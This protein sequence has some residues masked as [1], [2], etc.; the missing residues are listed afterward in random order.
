MPVHGWMLKQNARYALAGWREQKE[1]QDPLGSNMRAASI[2]LASRRD[3]SAAI[4][5]GMRLFGDE[6][7]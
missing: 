2:G 5:L 1:W 4:G 6:P 7:I 3:S